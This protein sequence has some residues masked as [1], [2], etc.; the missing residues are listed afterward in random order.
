MAG[1]MTDPFVIRFNQGVDPATV[2]AWSVRLLSGPDAV[3]GSPKAGTGLDGLPDPRIVVWTPDSPL[4]PAGS[5]RLWV[6]RDVRSVRGR[7]LQ[8]PFSAGFTTSGGKSTSALLDLDPDQRLTRAPSLGPAPRVRWTSPLAGLGNVYTDDV[9]IRFSRPMAADSFTGGN[10]T[11]FQGGVAVPGA[12]STPDEWGEREIQFSPEL[13]LFK[14]SSYHMVVTRDARTQL[15]RYLRREF[16]APFGTSPFKDGVKPVLPTDFAD[17]SVVLPVGRAFHTATPL[18]GGDIL[19]AG[20]QDLGGTPLASCFIYHASSGTFGA[21]APLLTARRKH[22]AVPTRTGGVMVIGGFGPTGTTLS[23]V[24]VYDPGAD[25]WT[26]VSSLAQS[27]A[28]ET[29]TVVSGY[30]IL[31]AGGFTNSSG[32][33]DYSPGAELF[34]PFT[35]AWSATTGPPQV[36]RGGHT[37]TLL[38]DGRVL[39]AGGTRPGVLVDEVYVPSTDS[40]IPTFPP[41][42]ERIFHA[43]CLTRAGTVLLAGGGPA[44]AEQFD[45]SNL[46]FSD[47]GSCPP[48]GLPVVTAPYYASLTLIPGGGRI[49]LIGGF[50][51]GGSSDGSDLVLDQVQVWDPGGGGGVGAFNPMLFDLKVPRA[52]HTVNQLPSGS[53][54]I[55]GGFGTDGLSN[56]RSVTIFTPS[57]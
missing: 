37:A 16:E 43:A 14:G 11:V 53:F 4:P 46:G 30:R 35:G 26:Q 8:D 24:E 23:T 38:P 2:T 27:R 55:L 42:E 50:V 6:S 49:V 17:G 3:P 31:V 56:E 39:L 32:T 33:L 21:A 41:L 51:P 13:P 18:P 9:I 47:A 25:S 40:F 12:L 20:G 1:L 44:R 5:W 45:P 28:S 7:P 48:R 19:V 52:A 29:A 15:G 36:V 34:N 57:L 54:L 22:A 10:F